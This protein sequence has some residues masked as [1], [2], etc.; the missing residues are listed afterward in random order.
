MDKKSVNSPIG[1]IAILL[2]VFQISLSI[3]STKL[4][5]D[6]QWT[7]IIF[8]MVYVV[9]VAIAFYLIL[10]FRPY[11]FYPPSEYDEYTKPADF[12]GAFQRTDSG[13]VDQK[14]LDAN[15]IIDQPI[16]ILQN[17]EETSDSKNSQPEMDW[18][19]YI[20]NEDFITARELIAEKIKNAANDDEKNKWVIRSAIALSNYE[21]SMAEKEFPELIKQYPNNYKIYYWFS[22]IYIRTRQ[23]NKALDVLENA[24]EIF[25]GN[26][27]PIIDEALIYIDI[28]EF[29]K[30][31]E[32]LEKVIHDDND[33]SNVAK[34][35]RLM[36][37][38]S[39]ITDDIDS[40]KEFY[41]K[42]YKTMPSDE[43]NIREIAQ[44]FYDTKNF[45]EELFFRL[46][47]VKVIKNPISWGLLGNCYL[48]NNLNNKAM[49]AYKKAEELGEEDE[50]IQAN[51]G[52][53]FNNVGLYNEAKK[54]LNTALKIQ[55]ESEYALN[56]LSKVM[57]KIAKEDEDEREIISIV[58]L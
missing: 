50:W 11:V 5:G 38:I 32:V 30:G 29:Q 40:A 55:P 3:A 17:K 24:T 16:D 33:P 15:D 14:H 28:N 56:R 25:K 7:V 41:L 21:F 52:N 53:L 8:S 37:L 58:K 51:I 44:F 4:T 26:D 20:K 42:A 47:H 9:I 27:E 2:G 48:V 35:Y 57:E 13:Q 18:F 12:I 43:T 45:K 22:R 54:H 1:I 39:K 6:Q 34:A 23:F 19:Y 10:I 31:K 49:S 36:G 46:E